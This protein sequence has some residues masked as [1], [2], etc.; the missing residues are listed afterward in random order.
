MISKSEALEYV[1][2]YLKADGGTYCLIYD[3]PG[4]TW[5]AILSKESILISTSMTKTIAKA[6][7]PGEAME[8]LMEQDNEYNL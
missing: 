6:L 4:D 7:T 2:E 3:K 5:V 8:K 1:T